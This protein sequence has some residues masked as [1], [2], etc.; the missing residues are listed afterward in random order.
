MD[1]I[2]KNEN[3]VE[4]DNLLY[5]N[6]VYET[7]TQCKCRGIEWDVLGAAVCSYPSCT[8]PYIFLWLISIV[9]CIKKCLLQGQ[10]GATYNGRCGFIGAHLTFIVSETNCISDK[11]VWPRLY[12]CDKLYY[13]LFIFLPLSLVVM[14]VGF[15]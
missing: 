13:S 8:V 4:L 14:V 6:S 11:L 10:S 9:G 7:Y 12:E 15:F 5:V 2:E 1:L 3:N